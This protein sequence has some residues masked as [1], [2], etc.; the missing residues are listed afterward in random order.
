MEIQRHGV[1]P[2]TEIH[3]HL[4]QVAE[5]IVQVTLR[6]GAEMYGG[7]LGR[8]QGDKLTIQLD[9]S[10]VLSK[11]TY[12]QSVHVTY[13]GPDRIYLFHTSVLSVQDG[14][15]VLVIPQVVEWSER[16]IA[17]RRNF[18]I[19][20]GVKFRCTAIPNKP[21]YQVNDISAQGLSLLNVQDPIPE[22]GALLAGELLIGGLAPISV[23]LSIAHL[24]LHQG[25]LRLG[26]RISKM[27]PKDH[28]ELWS[29]ISRM[30]GG[31]L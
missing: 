28:Q 16:R 25:Q 24:K 11:L 15:V 26:A 20:D 21:I 8:P 30:G 22:V 10:S 17:P 3:K 23:V 1:L 6:V 19:S 14:D 27:A 9:A 7:R 29:Y 18:T 2:R 12:G 13:N 5:N 31:A 4:L